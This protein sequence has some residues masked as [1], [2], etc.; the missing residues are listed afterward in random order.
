MTTAL[1]YGPIFLEHITPANHP[2]QP[3]RLQV[4]MDVL[5]ALNWLER[6]GLVQLAPRAANEDEL[7]A[8]HELEYIRK[9]EAAARKVAEEEAKGGRKTRFF[10]TDTY[11][12]AKSYEAAIRG[13]GAPLTSIDAILTDGIE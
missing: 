7:A 5:Q 4:A 1:I 10:A 13:A 6:D 11:V 3:Q 8:V 12:S 9:V 2:E